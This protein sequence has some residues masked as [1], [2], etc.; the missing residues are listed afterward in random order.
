[1]P[2]DEWLIGLSFRLHFK[3]TSITYK[4]CLINEDKMMGLILVNNGSVD[5]PLLLA[6]LLCYN[7]K[8]QRNTLPI[9]NNP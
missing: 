8:L 5:I 9:K 2:Q 7:L 6:S 1:M 3:I 4:T